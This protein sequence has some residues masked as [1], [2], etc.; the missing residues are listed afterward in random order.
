[1]I[2]IFSTC[3]VLKQSQAIN[4]LFGLSFFDLEG[5]GQDSFG[6]KAMVT[7]FPHA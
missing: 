2:F 3:R 4:G 7:C 1:M 6:S 5:E